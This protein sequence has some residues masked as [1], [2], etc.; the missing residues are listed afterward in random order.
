VIHFLSPIYLY[1]LSLLIVPVI[2][3]LFNFRRYKRV[4]F[5]NVRFLQEL[6]EETT[7]ISRLKHLLVL[8][9][10]LLAIAFI[11]LAF[12][13]PII[14]VGIQAAQNLS[15]PVSVY[16]D[17]SFSM[18]AIS[19]QGALL[20]VAKQKATEIAN[21]YPATTRFQLLTNDFDAYRQR[22]I[23]K[24]DFL[25]ELNRVKFSAQPRFLT[26]VILRQKEVATA[27]SA[28]GLTS[29]LISDFQKSTSDF[30]KVQPD[31]SL[32]VK[33]VVLPLQPTANLYVDSCWLSSP[34]VQLGQALEFTLSIQNS[35]AKD[36]ENVPVRLMLNGTQKAVTSLTIPAGQKVET[37]FS[38]T[39][40]ESGWQKATIKIADHP[41]NFD[42]DY[43]FSFEVKEKLHVLS[44][45]ENTS[46]YLEALFSKDPFFEFVKSNANGVDYANFRKQDLI[47]LQ[48]LRQISSGLSEELKKYLE[49]GGSICLFPDSLA[50]L[51]N[52]NLFLT[53]V[54]ADA[55]TGINENNDRVSEVDLQHALFKDVF[56]NKPKEGRI[57]F[58]AVA[59]HFDQTVN[60]KSVRQVL[61]KLQGGGSFL[62]L[63]PVEKGQLY[64]FSVPL[65]TGF[66]NLARHAIFVP[67][68]YRMAI[69]TSKPLSFSHAIGSNDAILLNAAPPSGDEA[70]HLISKE[71][72]TDIIPSARAIASGLMIDMGNQV[73]VAGHY[74]L[75][76]ENQLVAALA[77]NYDRKESEM[78]F[79][80]EAMIQE[81]IETLK[82][83]N[84]SYFNASTPDLKKTLLDLNNGISLWKYAIISAL[85]CLL[86]EILLIR[87]WK[88]A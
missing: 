38:F 17:N 57:D 85:V 50:D 61:M 78:I 41:L 5:T 22:L 81:K 45:S 86:L 47:V 84:W 14:P 27:G 67:V 59:K 32:T 48:G 15:N 49:S 54:N 24:D 3:H 51:N 58:P 11:V 31:S 75:M 83:E 87:F 56:D 69:L 42:D 12:A 30:E 9:T 80:N 37:T 65:Q 43:Y 64:V 39:A 10:R 55:F 74:D 40:S 62:S 29:Y 18:D 71:A 2:I 44:I 26:E 68:L 70:F 13:Q 88:T 35:S 6:K 79:Y 63:Y 19:S 25:D 36:A 20:E 28:A 23:S 53:S 82:L 76:K 33:M 21:S 46:P 73:Q 8:L 77:F 4:L 1:G 66:S 34:I 52:F 7:K 72:N 16:I 60:S